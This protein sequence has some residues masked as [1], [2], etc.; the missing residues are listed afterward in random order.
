[1]LVQLLVKMSSLL[2][3][4]LLLRQLPLLLL[5]FVAG[6]MAPRCCICCQGRLFVVLPVVSFAEAAVAGLQRP[7]AAPS[8]DEP[9]PDYF[10]PVHANNTANTL[11]LLGILLALGI[12]SLQSLARLLLSN[13]WR[14]HSPPEFPCRL[15]VDHTIILCCCCC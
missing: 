6:I 10:L 15:V 5:P 8:H 7:L 9:S 12:V 4:P 11:L 2:P 1:L 14:W 3:R 13:I